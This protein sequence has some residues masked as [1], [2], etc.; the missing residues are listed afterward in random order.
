M[1]AALRLVASHVPGH[2]DAKDLALRLQGFGRPVDPS[3]VLAFIAAAQAYEEVGDELAKEH[4]DERD[5]YEKDA[6]K[7]HSEIEDLKRDN[8]KLNEKLEE[9]RNNRSYAEY[10][11]LEA[12]RDALAQSLVTWNTTGLCAFILDNAERQRIENVELKAKLARIESVLTPKQIKA[13]R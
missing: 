5:E 13:L 3:E 4:A 7:L 12:E 2:V 11:K 6:A 1:S 10:E 8:A 9:L